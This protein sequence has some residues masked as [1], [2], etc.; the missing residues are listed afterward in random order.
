MDAPLL[1]EEP[2]SVVV[3]TASTHLGPSED[4]EGGVDL[5]VL[6][7]EDEEAPQEEEETK[8]EE[9]SDVGGIQMYNPIAR[10]PRAP[11][12][13]PASLE[14][15]EQVSGTRGAR[16]TVQPACVERRLGTGLCSVLT[17]WPLSILVRF[18]G[19]CHEAPQP[20]RPARREIVVSCSGVQVQVEPWAGQVPLRPEGASGPGP[21]LAFGGF[22]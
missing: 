21:S 2:A 18:P 9:P 4:P 3:P 10:R 5:Q 12:K 16:V 11:A 8:D 14:S 19:D 15:L 6:V 20:G 1:Q 17:C 22:W 13:A 7:A